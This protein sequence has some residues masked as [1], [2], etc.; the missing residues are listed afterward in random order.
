MHSI[1]IKQLWVSLMQD[2]LQTFFPIFVQT[3]KKNDFANSCCG[4]L[5]VSPTTGNVEWIVWNL[6]CLQRRV[7]VLRAWAAW[8]T[9]SLSSGGRRGRSAAKVRRQQ[10]IY[11]RLGPDHLRRRLTDSLFVWEREWLVPGIQPLCPQ[12]ARGIMCSLRN[13]TYC[14]K[15][16]CIHCSAYEGVKYEEKPCVH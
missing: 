6:V 7:A 9:W 12:N 1:F 14:W 4:S 11:I 13:T 8:L 2:F 16:S 5:M 10:G 3:R 15:L